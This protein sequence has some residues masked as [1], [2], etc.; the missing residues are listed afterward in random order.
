MTKYV[1]LEY[2]YTLKVHIRMNDKNVTVFRY[3]CGF[4]MKLKLFSREFIIIY[5]SVREKNIS[6]CFLTAFNVK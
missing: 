6:N 2:G 1:P 4:L 5:H 3:S